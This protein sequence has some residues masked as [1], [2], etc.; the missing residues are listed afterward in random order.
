[1]ACARRNK[2]T[3]RSTL[4][5]RKKVT[6]SALMAKAG[7]FCPLDDSILDLVRSAPA[8]TTFEFA[9]NE[10]RDASIALSASDNARSLSSS[11]YAFEEQSRQTG[12]LRI[13]FGPSFVV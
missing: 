10:A 11:M 4:A 12:E 6:A 3:G 7:S 8:N 13:L 9:S 1:M 2:K 5:L